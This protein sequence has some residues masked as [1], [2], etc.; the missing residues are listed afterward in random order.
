MADLMAMALDHYRAGRLD[1][2]LEILAPLVTPQ[3]DPS[4]ELLLL[5]GQCCARTERYR[6]GA[7]Y[8]ARAAK[9]SPDRST[10]LKAMAAEL[11]SL[12]D[13]RRTALSAARRNVKTGQFDRN[14]MSSY[15][16]ML[17]E[18]LCLDERMMEDQS[19]LDRMRR[20]D[21]P[22][23]GI[24]HHL[25]H[26]SWCADEA[27]NA[28]QSM[29]AEKGFFSDDSRRRRRERP[30]RFGSRIRI[31]YLSNDYSD[32]HPTM[33]LFRGVLELHDPARFEVTLYCHTDQDLINQDAGLRSRFGNIVQIGELSDQAAADLIRRHEIDILID[34]KGHTKGVRMGVVNAG[35]API[36]VAYLGFPGSGIGIDCDYVIGDAIVLPDSSK[37]HYHEKFCLLPECY[38]ANDDM[39][40]PLPPATPRHR[41]GLP[42][43]RLILASFNAARKI[44]PHTTETWAK[45]LAQLP[46]SILWIMCQGD[47]ARQNFVNWMKNQDIVESRI[48][49]AE[50]RN[51]TDHLSR[52]QAA[53]I[54]LDSFPYNGHTSTSDALWTGVPVPTYAGTHFAS[55]VGASL[56]TA[57]GL[58][59]LIA[60]DAGSYVDL[61]VRLGRDHR[62]REAI[63]K[64]IRTN[65]RTAPLFDTHRFTRHL[66]TAFEMMVARLKAG[67]EPDHFTVPALPR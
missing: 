19:L 15:R 16:L 61:C 11:L 49:F 18:N 4:L 34:L 62:W 59:E 63:G 44:T 9:K 67:L 23:L 64:K 58:P 46:E 38:Q 52:L 56:L 42:D 35:C 65:R 13:E 2:T 57:L 27:I 29:G 66:E 12:A 10:L 24:E 43:D 8:F 20:G 5:A 39:F 6:P 47:F 14:A 1:E 33:I 21:A 32:A 31:G 7:D 40:R 50:P 36:Q 51:Y 3:A 41:L 60:A 55:R 37:P 45:I 22:H 26:I 25:A 28:R 48:V 53:D 30:H 17:H 54:I